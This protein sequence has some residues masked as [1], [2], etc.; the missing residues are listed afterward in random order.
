M[1]HKV[2][3]LI[4]DSHLL[5][6]EAWHHMLQPEFEVVRIVTDGRALVNEAL[7]LHP[8]VVVLEVSLPQL[9][10][11]DAATQI[12]RKL[13]YMKLVFTTASL[14][15]EVAAE[16]FRQ[17]TSAYVPK[18]A[19]SEE[20]VIAIRTVMRG[21]SYLSSLIAR[22]TITPLLYQPNR[23]SVKRRLTRRQG[24]ILQLLAEG[25]TMKEAADILNIAPG[26]VAFHKYQM[27]SSL[28]ID[29]NAGLLQYAM[30]DHIPPLQGKLGC[31]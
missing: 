7:A 8:D 25:R 23:R 9:N 16:A 10:G 31:Y 28:G 6:A 30:R 5:V 18:Q 24:E 1:K 27:M 21:E 20:L 15:S 19:P 26:T 12:K 11:L 3:L 17:G 4:A 22:E 2:R 29:T 14:D 13:P